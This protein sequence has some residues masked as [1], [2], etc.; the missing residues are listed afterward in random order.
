MK[1]GRLPR[2]T[3]MQKHRLRMFQNV[4]VRHCFYKSDGVFRRINCVIYIFFTRYVDVRI[5]N[6]SK[7]GE[8]ATLAVTSCV[9]TQ[10]H[11]CSNRTYCQE[12]WFLAF[13]YQQSKRKEFNLYLHWRW[14]QY[15]P[16]SPHGVTTQKNNI[17][18]FTAVR[19]SSLQYQVIVSNVK[20]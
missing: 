2:A 4:S 9:D 6:L 17:D 7:Q 18:I 1:I 16:T 5:I 8:K 14:R 11:N 10:H 3:R 19:T 20:A 13:I 12:H 15:L